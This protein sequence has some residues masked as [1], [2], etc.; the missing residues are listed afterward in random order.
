MHEIKYQAYVKHLKWIAPVIAIYFESK[1]V[2]VDFTGNGD[3]AEYSFDEVELIAY[4]NFKDVKGAEVNEGDI[5]KVNWSKDTDKGIVK[6]F[7][8]GFY[9]MEME[10]HSPIPLSDMSVT[11]EVI[12]N[13]YENKEL[14]TN[15]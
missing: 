1:E 5:V 6:W 13:I 3:I 8:Y 12:G 9:V 10:K 11:V 2:E 15:K 7:S 14:L 4:T